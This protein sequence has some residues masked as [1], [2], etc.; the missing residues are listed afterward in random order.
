[1]AYH[2]RS[3]GSPSLSTFLRALSRGYIHG[4]PLLTHTLVRKFPPLS[5]AT[6]YGHLDTLRQG[7]ASTRRTPPPTC[8]SVASNASFTPYPPPLIQ[9]SPTLMTLPSKASP[10]LPTGANGRRPT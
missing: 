1:V 3:F 2:H 4:I 8:L 6:A 9:A 7:V 5:L 10:S